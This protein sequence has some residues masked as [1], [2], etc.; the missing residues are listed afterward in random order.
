M[1]KTI[2]IPES[3]EKATGRLAA[4]DGIA[5]ATGWERAAIIY[6]FTY[7]GTNRW[8]SGREVDRYTI[9]AF[10]KL[11]I[12][13]LKSKDTVIHYRHCWEDAMPAGEA[14]DIQPGERVALP[15]TRFPSGE[16]RD[17][18]LQQ[19]RGCPQDAAQ[20]RAAASGHPGGPGGRQAGGCQSHAR[21]RPSR[22]RSIRGASRRSEEVQDA[23][24]QGREAA[25]TRGPDGH[26][27]HDPQD[28]GAAV[29]R[30]R[31][32]AAQ[33]FHEAVQELAPY[34]TDEDREDFD[35]Y[36]DRVIDV[37]QMVRGGQVTDAEAEAFF[38]EETS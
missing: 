17:G 15:D 12:T 21:A 18:R 7:E 37:W 11:G 3:I 10:A 24:A 6:T 23:D 4:L 8:D 38:A 2:R 35:G 32:S 19:P 33:Q 13:G 22:P 34:I 25:S 9:S 36:V 14:T 20:D 5:T 16:P 27:G 30:R 26:G 29:L 1:V 31:P 28:G